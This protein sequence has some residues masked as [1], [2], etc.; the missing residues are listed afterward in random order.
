[1]TGPNTTPESAFAASA[2]D[3]NEAPYFRTLVENTSDAI[4]TLDTDSTI[5]FANPAVERLLGYH[6]DEL[7]G[8][9]TMQLVPERLRDQHFT[10]FSQ[11]L[12]SGT[13]T[14]D[15]DGIELPALHEDGHEIPV[16]ITLREH[17]FTDRRLFTGIIRDISDRK[18]REQRL[19]V[20]EQAVEHAGHSIYV[21]DP[22]GTITYVNSTFEEQTGYTIEE[23]IGE[24]PQILNSG[25]H[26]KAF[27]A[28]LWGTILSGDVWTGEVVNERKSGE[29]YTIN[30]TIAPI[31]DETGDIEHFVAINADITARKEREQALRRQ[32]NTL[33]RVRQVTDSL[34]AID[35]LL[36][37]ATTREELQQLVCDR[38]A[39]SEAYTFTWI[40]DHVTADH[41][42]D[43]HTWAGIEDNSLSEVDI[44]AAADTENE[45]GPTGRA[46]RTRSV[47]AAQD[48]LHDPSFESWREQAIERGYRAA[49]AVPLVYGGALYGVLG[50]YS[51]RPFAFDDYEQALLENLGE[52]I[53]HA[54]HALENQQLLHTDSVVELEFESTSPEDLFIRLSEEFACRF[55]LNRL[56]PLSDG[57]YTG[58]ISVGGVAPDRVRDRLTSAAVV[59]DVRV[60]RATESQGVIEC[61]FTETSPAVTLTKHGA[62]VT[63]SVAEN[64][65]KTLVGELP[66]EA[67]T[68]P[69]VERLLAEFPGTEF[70][71]KR[72]LDRSVNPLAQLDG[73]TCDAVLTDRQ[74]EVLEAAYHAGFFASPRHSTG[75]EIAATLDISSPT[76]YQHVR[77]AT[78][79]LLDVILD[80]AATSDSPP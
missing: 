7:V 53:G 39:S 17:E 12:E 57:R 52:R 19:R 25:E 70:I 8:K 75:D 6:P 55:E 20:F 41:A 40:G 28:D 73:E 74:Q 24:T 54:I 46:V 21:T 38:L 50:V 49:A 37:Q 18:E 78:E 5:V 10:A 14:I 60:T 11:Y 43:P 27:Y 44:T 35:P 16:S 68:R 76:F 15:W 9:S 79:N 29:Q 42:I 36:T 13:R 66:A 58:Y 2:A 26:D 48:I 22:D 30:Q 62:K 56:V 31:T 69:A 23:A 64:G 67:D 51:A 1:M 77:K 34:H 80:D 4:L 65:T 61:T 3:L 72:T 59:E 33:E 32:R 63:T 71:S 45:H 47:Q